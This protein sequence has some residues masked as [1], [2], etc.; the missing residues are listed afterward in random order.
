[1]QLVAGSRLAVLAAGL[2]C[3]ALGAVLG[4]V[5]GRQGGAPTAP[6]SA[7][8]S[9]AS[10]RAAESASQSAV[11]AE[12][13]ARAASGAHTLAKTDLAA[14]ATARRQA[15]EFAVRAEKA[16][17]SANAAAARTALDR[18][19]VTDAARARPPVAQARP[20]LPAPL[21]SAEPP[22]SRPAARAVR[23]IALAPPAANDEG[24]RRAVIYERTAAAG[25]TTRQAA[26]NAAMSG[27]AM[28]AHC[29]EPQHSLNEAYLLAQRASAEAA[30]HVGDWKADLSRSDR[31]LA[32][33]TKRP[34]YRGTASAG[35]LTR[36][37]K[38]ERI[39]LAMQRGR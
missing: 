2:A 38:N 25:A 31:L 5:A 23:K 24:C 34:E 15:Q 21:V 9:P 29:G 36:L 6:I 3:I 19:A 13:W 26:Y 17:A 37:R 27:F 33:C 20:A 22:P 8:V 28:N 10:A 39:R 1:M 11:A 16:A 14:A 18:K 32:R 35:C 30:L 4:W 12:G 7:G